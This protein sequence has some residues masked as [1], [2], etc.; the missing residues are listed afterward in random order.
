MIGGAEDLEEETEH[1]TQKIS[2]IYWTFFKKDT[3][4]TWTEEQQN[5]INCDNKLPQSEK[6]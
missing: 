1:K 6:N 5:T 2:K 3:K 4:V